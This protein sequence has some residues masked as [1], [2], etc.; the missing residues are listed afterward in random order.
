MNHSYNQPSFEIVKILR[1][2]TLP[3][4]LRGGESRLNRNCRLYRLRPI[5]ELAGYP[6]GLS[7]IL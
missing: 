2:V 6:T 5:V 1:R 3:L 4:N 7:T